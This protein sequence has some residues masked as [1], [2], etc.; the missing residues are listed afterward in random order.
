MAEQRT[1]TASGVVLPDT[2]VVKKMQHFNRERVPERRVHPKG[3]AAHGF[4]EVTADVTQCAER[5]VP[6]EGR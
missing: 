1:T 5:G 4:F 6:V 2:L 3:S